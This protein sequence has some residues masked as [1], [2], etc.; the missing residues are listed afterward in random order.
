MYEFNNDQKLFAIFASAF[1][2]NQKLY[3]QWEYAYL[4]GNA[5]DEAYLAEKLLFEMRQEKWF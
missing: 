1:P 4:Q 5:S 2:E 3:D